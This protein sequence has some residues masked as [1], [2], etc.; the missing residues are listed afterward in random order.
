MNVTL[1]INTGPR[2]GERIA[3]SRAE[4]ILIG[5]GPEAHVKPSD[6]DHFVSRRHMLLRIDPPHCLLVD[7]G[8]TNGTYLNGERVTGE[9]ELKEGDRIRV[10]AM[11]FAITGLD[12]DRATG[13][14]ETGEMWLCRNCRGLAEKANA[15]GRA[16]DIA[17]AASYLCGRCVEKIA[18]ELDGLR[19]GPYKLL[20]L[21]GQGTMGAV[22]EAVDERTGRFVALKQM[23]PGAAAKEKVAKLFQR[24]MAV[25]QDLRHKNIVRLIDQGVDEGRHYF[26]SEYLDGGDAGSLIKSR[27][28]AASVS[29]SSSLIG[30]ILDGLQYA[31]ER[32]YVHR[33][34]KPQNMLLAE[35]GG[36]LVAKIADFGLA[37]NF[38]AAGASFMTRH[39]ESA[40]TLLYMAPEQIKNFRYVKPTAD[41]YSAGVSFYYLL[42]GRFPFHFPSPLDRVMGGLFGKKQK[43]ELAIVLEDEPIPLLEQAPGISPKLAEVV[44][45]SIRKKEEERYRS[46]VEMKLEIEK[47]CCGKELSG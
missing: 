20:R 5:R 9:V 11:D 39:G 25:L 3:F 18:T 6:D 38:A 17:G 46:A 31:H 13:T 24:E 8:S 12:T 23:L 28:A 21:L 45:R 27:R 33:D 15:D 44:D 43:S 14:F 22:Y 32:N 4:T 37:K 47:A 7:L 19:I 2:A 1:T 35:S 26:V 29:E 41:L 10:G 30:Q 16:A 40:G 42:T 34:I 36:Q